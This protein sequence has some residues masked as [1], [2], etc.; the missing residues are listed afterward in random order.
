MP[1]LSQVLFDLVLPCGATARVQILPL[2]FDKEIR[3]RK[4]PPPNLRLDI[5]FV[6]SP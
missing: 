3:R 6:N 2:P 1:Y 4:I 5:G